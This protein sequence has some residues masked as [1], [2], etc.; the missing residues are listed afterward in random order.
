MGQRCPK[1]G[2]V[3][4]PRPPDRRRAH[5]RRGRAAPLGTVTTFC[6]VNV[7]FHGQQMRSRT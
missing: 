3:Y 6:V 2:K 1:C 5:H 4:L 7:P